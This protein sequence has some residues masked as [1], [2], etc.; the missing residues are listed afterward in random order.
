[1]GRYLWVWPQCECCDGS[2]MC[3]NWRLLLNPLFKENSVL[4]LS[5]SMSCCTDP[6]QLCLDSSFSRVPVDSSYWA[7]SQNSE[8]SGMNNSSVNA[9]GLRSVINTPPPLFILNIP[10]PQLSSWL[11]SWDVRTPVIISFS[12]HCWYI[13][14]LTTKQG[15]IKRCTNGSPSFLTQS[16]LL[17]MSKQHHLR[18]WLASVVLA[19]LHGVPCLLRHSGKTWVVVLWVRKKTYTQRGIFLCGGKLS[20]ENEKNQM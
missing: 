19:M 7:M 12:G 10:H 17:R 5:Q 9:L 16:S 3:G 1:M 14:L 4:W 6:L 18:L 11:Y 15:I 8:I 2:Q 13:Y 20:F